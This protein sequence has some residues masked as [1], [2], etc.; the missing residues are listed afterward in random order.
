MI[1]A[2]CLSSTSAPR[3]SCEFADVRHGGCTAAITTRDC[4][5]V[6][7]SV[8][9]LR[10][11]TSASRLA[12]LTEPRLRR[13]P[14]N[15]VMAFRLAVAY[16]RNESVHPRRSRG[17]MIRSRERRNRRPRRGTQ[18]HTSH[19]GRDEPLRAL[20]RTLARHAARELFARELRA[21]RSD[22]P[23]VRGCDL[24]AVLLGQSTRRLDR[25]PAPDLPRVRRSPGAGR[26][27][28]SSPITRSRERRS[29]TLDSRR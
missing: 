28:R 21:Q 12:G 19:D 16:E 10:F 11:A 4:P 17:V 7:G 1:A 23:E 13:C 8:K 24:R 15:Y 5:A 27:F 22:R 20:V 2:S 29:C 9:P 26:S 6:H 14:R 25:R 18:A 3:S